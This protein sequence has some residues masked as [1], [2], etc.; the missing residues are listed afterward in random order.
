MTDVS[1]D[2][3]PPWDGRAHDEPPEEYRA[4]EEEQYAR[5]HRSLDHGGG[6]CDCPVA[7]IEYATEAP[8]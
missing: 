7:E 8:F 1:D 6:E 3:N 2:C 5:R 4:E